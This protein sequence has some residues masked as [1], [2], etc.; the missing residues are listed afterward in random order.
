[1]ANQNNKNKKSNDYFSNSIRHKG[2]GFIET[3]TSQDLQRDAIRVLRDLSRGNI[4]IEQH[5]HYFLEPMFLENI[6]LAIDSKLLVE[7]ILR[8]GTTMLYNHQVQ[9]GQPSDI[10]S[11]VLQNQLQKVE[12]FQLARTNLYG[13]KTSGDLSWLYT[14]AAQLSNY[15]YII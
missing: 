5:G 4:D 12:A 1:M 7:T 15:R 11:M 13:L 2:P 9:M 3:K 8:D 6:I 10:T 14:L